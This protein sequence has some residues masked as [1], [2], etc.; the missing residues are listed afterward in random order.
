MRQNY[1][2]T[3]LVV[4]ILICGGVMSASAKAD[5]MS[6]K[7]GVQALY[8]KISTAY[9]Q[10]DADAILDT[11]T[12]DYKLLNPDGSVHVDD[13]DA[14]RQRLLKIW[15]VASSIEDHALARKVVPS[16]K[17]AIITL[18]DDYTR[19]QSKPELGLVGKVLEVGTL[20]AY[21][22]NSSSGWLIKQERIISMTSIITVNGKLKS[23]KV[24]GQPVK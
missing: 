12:E 22:V 8:N 21:L 19:T 16:G 18:D 15:S 6:T 10:R 7:Q 13:K 24:W 4:S 1:K 14:E 11:R 20:R 9:K 2:F 3:I 23:K 5:E 17:D